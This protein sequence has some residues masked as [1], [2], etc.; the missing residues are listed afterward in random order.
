MGDTPINMVEHTPETSYNWYKEE[1]AAKGSEPAPGA[2]NGNPRGSGDL[3]S[4]Y[5]QDVVTQFDKHRQ[6]I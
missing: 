5:S 1:R 2:F 3:S 4:I 6:P